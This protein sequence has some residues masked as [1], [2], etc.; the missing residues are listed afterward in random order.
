MILEGKL[1]V[2]AVSTYLACPSD[3]FV[4]SFIHS[5]TGSLIEHALTDVRESEEQKSTKTEPPS[6]NS[7][8]AQ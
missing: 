4:H 2:R 5:F 7:I 1:R 6:L 3:V 8:A